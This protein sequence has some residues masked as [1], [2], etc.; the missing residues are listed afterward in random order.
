MDENIVL[1]FALRVLVQ[2]RSSRWYVALVPLDVLKPHEEVDEQ[3]LREL[4]KQIVSEGVLRYPIVVDM[5]TMTILNGHHRV[6]I[7]KRL[8]KKYVP[9][10]LVDYDSDC[11]QVTSW[12]PGWNVT[13]ELVRKV[14]LAGMRLPP[15]TSR[16]ILCFETPR[17]DVPLDTLL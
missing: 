6:E 4:M 1:R 11:I 14:A 15:R 5:K 9:A 2:D 16:H 13:K 17:V 8:G 10:L 12:R 7:L 3:H